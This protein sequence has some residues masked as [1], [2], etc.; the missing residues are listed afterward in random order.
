MHDGKLDDLMK[1]STDITEDEKKFRKVADELIIVG[2]LQ[3][4][5]PLGADE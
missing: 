1:H 3:P 2:I 4:V 5:S